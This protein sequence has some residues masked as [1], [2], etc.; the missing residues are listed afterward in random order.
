MHA[1]LPRNFLLA[2]C[3]ACASTTVAAANPLGFYVGAGIGESEIRRDGSFLDADYR[4]DEYHAGWKVI[5]GI[6]P[7]SPL[8]LELEYID[9]GRASAGINDYFESS[10]VDARAT[11][12]FGV[13]YLPLPVPFLDIYGKVA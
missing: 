1:A 2:L 8:G 3:T 7:V 9:F 10:S 13:G 11:T 12:L 5:L 4:Y 6:R